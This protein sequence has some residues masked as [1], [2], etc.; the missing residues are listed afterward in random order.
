MNDSRVV[1]APKP[2]ARE[3]GQF[4]S[5]RTNGVRPRPSAPHQS[6]LP[7]KLTGRRSS[8][9]PVVTEAAAAP[10]RWPDLR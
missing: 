2:S 9:E 4:G 7:D 8:P 5:R 10:L 3:G 1:D 6:T